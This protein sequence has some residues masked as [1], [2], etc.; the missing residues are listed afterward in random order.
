MLEVLMRYQARP[1]QAD[2]LAAVLDEIATDAR[3]AAGCTLS[4]VWRNRKRPDRFVT[5]Q[6]WQSEDAMHDFLRADLLNPRGA[7]VRDATTQ[8][9]E[10][11]MFDPQG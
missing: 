4:E 2:A 1:E 9:P 5:R 8:L 3:A 7:I 10:L 6:Q 11:E